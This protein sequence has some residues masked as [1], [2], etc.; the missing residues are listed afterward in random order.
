M[1]A[2]AWSNSVPLA[3]T[4][5]KVVPLSWYQLVQEN[6]PVLKQL[7]TTTS[8]GVQV[9]LP[10]AFITQIGGDASKYR[11]SLTKQTVDPDGGEIKIT[12]KTASNFRVRNCGP[13]YG[14]EV[15]VLVF[16][17]P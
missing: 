9:D 7:I 14:E 3:V 11:V 6:I 17:M 4:P 5:F 8:G 13:S 16:W 2:T 12:D 10:A 15:L 1:S